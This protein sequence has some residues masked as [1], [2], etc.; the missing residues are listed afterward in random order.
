MSSAHAT[1]DTLEL[2]SGAARAVVDVAHG[3]RLTSFVVAGHELLTG[4]SN[5][6]MPTSL[7]SGSY[8]MAP[9]AGR[10]RDG[11]FDFAGA[12]HQMPRNAGRHAIHGLAH[13]VAWTEEGPNRISVALGEPW[14]FGGRLSQEFTLTGAELVTT[15]TATATQHAMPVVLGFH[16]WFR[17]TLDGGSA[18]SL[19]FQAQHQYRRADDGVPDGTLIDPLPDPWDDCFVIPSRQV[20]I[21]WPGVMLLRVR[22][23]HD[24]F[25]VY[26]QRDDSLGVEPQTAAPDAFNSGGATVLEPGDSL[27]LTMTLQW[28]LL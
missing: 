25:V 19:S 11:A 8:P 1:T 13:D 24:H 26:N 7:L 22:S 6:E 2:H 14:P 10:V 17:N 28:E 21:A 9:W 15:L 5:P 18:A 12:T 3:G 23:D 4:V 27:T 16:P 20:A